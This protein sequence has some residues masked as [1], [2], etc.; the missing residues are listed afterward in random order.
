MHAI[1]GIGIRGINWNIM[2]NFSNMNPLS[3]VMAFKMAFFL[4]E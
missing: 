3:L 1:R 2:N 4:S